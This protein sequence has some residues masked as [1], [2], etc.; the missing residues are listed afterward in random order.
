MLLSFVCLNCLQ[1]WDWS[2]ASEYLHMLVQA[3][4]ILVRRSWRPCRICAG[5]PCIMQDL[6]TCRTSPFT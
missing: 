4:T 1:A 6:S 5:A 2:F 3:I